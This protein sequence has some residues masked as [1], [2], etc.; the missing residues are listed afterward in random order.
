MSRVLTLAVCTPLATAGLLLWLLPE[1]EGVAPL[2]GPAG[3][4]AKVDPTRGTEILQAEE[5]RAGA[6]GSAG[7]S[8]ARTAAARVVGR[9]L[10]AVTGD[11][12]PGFGVQL[13][14][15]CL[16]LAEGL[17]DG[18]GRFAIPLPAL[19][20]RFVEL[21][22]SPGWRGED[23]RV[24]PSPAQLAGREEVIL[25]ARHVGVGP[26]KGRVFE[27]FTGDPV[28]ELDLRLQDGRGRVAHV[29]SGADGRFESAIRL[30]SG[31]LSVRY[32][33]GKGE[34]GRWPVSVAFDALSEEEV[35][36]RVA[37]GATYRL[38]LV[39]PA[40]VKVSWLGACLRATDDAAP[41]GHPRD[42]QR[43]RE[44]EPPWVRFD[45]RSLF[46]QWGRGPP[47]ILEVAS[48]SRRW[49]GRAEV[50]SITGVHPGSIRV[51][52]HRR[53]AIA[54]RVLDDRGE[55]ISGARIGIGPAQEVRP[56]ELDDSISTGT[57]GRFEF[58]GLEA[59]EYSLSAW[60]NRHRPESLTVAL[61][62][63]EERDLEIRLARE[64]G[65]G[66]IA[67]VLRVHGGELPRPVQLRLGTVDLPRRGFYAQAEF[68]E[69][70]GG[71]VAPFRIE[72]VPQAEYEL[73]PIGWECLQWSPPSLRVSPPAE[74]LELVR[75]DLAAARSLVF[76]VLDAESGEPLDWAWVLLRAGD[77][78]MPFE[79]EAEYPRHVPT[80]P[81]DGDCSWTAIA[82]GHRSA[83]GRIEG[84]SAIEISAESWR[85]REIQVRLSGLERS[86]PGPWC[87]RRGAGGRADPARRPGGGPDRLE[88]T[89][90]MQPV[91]RPGR[92]ERELPGLGPGRGAGGRA[93]VGLPRARRRAGAAAEAAGWVREPSGRIRAVEAPARVLQ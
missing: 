35:A 5:E 6:T 76:R 64:P 79:V 54:G 58:E 24:E 38:V 60:S 8:I 61:G 23:A 19:G 44:G 22:E 26:V 10:D 91:V 88:G 92:R 59:G 13:S 63:G 71:W 7:E 78:V 65:A 48:H 27:V 81:V 49:V 66:A 70:P 45:S 16:V 85:P 39:M 14:N 90:A 67:G 87:R 28:P 32:R 31:F 3:R 55:P 72:E 89:G 46:R 47:W 68:K 40:E 29:T 34:Y 37:C 83:R 43:T 1:G 52:L 51:V 42:S 69:A 20:V 2:G 11:P 9:A 57:L 17:T 50:S 93:G 21:V 41:V 36:V 12:L 33:D 62:E 84:S 80:C 15:E 75:R 56:V 4:Q 86:G 82:P 25:R 30:E 53:G 18:E 77:A 74:D 73:K